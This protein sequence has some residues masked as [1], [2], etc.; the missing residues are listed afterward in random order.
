MTARNY[1]NAIIMVCA[2]LS[3]CL[4]GTAQQT[5]PD[6]GKL[7]RTYQSL[8]DV[9]V[10]GQ[11]APQSV[12][13]S[14]YRVRTIDRERIALRGATDITGVLNSE[15]GMRFSTDYT[16]GETD[17]KI[18]GLGAQRVKV[19]LDGVPLID[20]DGTKQSLGQID[21]NT[22]ERIEIVEGPM[23][24]VYG[25]D[26]L[27]G[28]INIITKKN[29][30]GNN[31]T[32][33]ARVQ[34]ESAGKKYSPFTDNGVHNEYLGINWNKNNWQLSAWGTRNHFGGWNDT[35]AFPAKTWK[36]KKQW[37]TG[38]TIGYRHK[39]F[40]AWYRLDYLNEE[41]FAAGVMFT[42]SYAG[43]DKYYITNRYTHQAQADWTV[44]GKL[45]INTA[46]S[47]QDYKRS[48]ET[49]NIDYR[50]GTKTQ[51]D[52][53]GYW[54]VS[55][56]NTYFIRSTAQW[57]ISSSVAIQPGVE[58]KYDKTSGERITGTPS[59]TDYSFFASAELKPVAGVLLRPGVRF[60]NNSVYDAPPVIPSLNTKFTLNKNLDLRL[61][62]ARGFRA[63]ILRELYFF[64]HDAS[65]SIEGNPD[66]KAEYSNSFIGS[67]TW[68]KASAS[69]A[70][71]SSSVSGFYNDYRDFINLAFDAGRQVYTY[72]NTSKYKT[73]GGTF[74]NTLN[75]KS[76]SASL[77]FSYIGYYNE[78]ADDKS[79]AGDHSKFSWAPEVNS[80]I[81]YRIPKL[82]AQVGLFYKFNGALPSYALNADGDVFLSKIAAYHW[83]DITA[84]KR[85]FKFF[86]LQAGIKNLFNVKRVQNSST[87]AGSAH[88]TGGPVLTAYGTSF[89][90]GVNF[91]WSKH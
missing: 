87:D 48:T 20:R 90:A 78:Y 83:A 34:E 18:M 21:I 77:G 8:Q 60:S 27:A 45:S 13:N 7:N 54:D 86:T 5:Q 81:T 65:H 9:V 67:L 69:E 35:A 57:R 59:I 42:T 28:V 68:Q 26:A 79:I 53:D 44:N 2:I 52:G 91:Q 4:N 17:T 76:L 10:T 29:K 6:T 36:P 49:Y 61:S 74:E 85:L 15:L 47:Y 89:F 32:V 70:K 62:Y 66:L 39:N 51:A 14:V 82:D 46:V 24:V 38:G 12:K 37:I 40:N 41:L 31:L 11:Y 1:G 88:S 56:F 55:Q 25:T 22:V 58:I 23:S 33:T 80:N 71:I 73:V 19:L 30:G 3:L 72:F 50:A 63:P 75:W 43:L 64:F 84:S 16:L